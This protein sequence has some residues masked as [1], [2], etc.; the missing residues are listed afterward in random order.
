M[1]SLS[2]QPGVKLFYYMLVQH[3]AAMASRIQSL[4]YL[5]LLVPL[6]STTRFDLERKYFEGEFCDGKITGFGE[7]MFANG[8]SIQ[9]VWNEGRVEEQGILTYKNGL[10][11]RV[12]F[13]G[14]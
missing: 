2:R 6:T 4:A 5:G 3:L 14:D 8:D 13:Y 9:G 1:V 12:S 7:M 11:T 10:Q